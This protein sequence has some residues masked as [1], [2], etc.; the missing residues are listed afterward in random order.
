MLIFFCLLDLSFLVFCYL[1]YPGT[2]FKKPPN[3]TKR[4]PKQKGT[5][6]FILGIFER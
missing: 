3:K 5:I 4:L 2:Y 6:F 1:L